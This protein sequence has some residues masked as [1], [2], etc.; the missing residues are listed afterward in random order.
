MSDSA[1]LASASICGEPSTPVIAA[2]GPAAAQYP[3]DVSRPATQ[4]DH[5][6]RMFDRY[7]RDQ[8]QCR[9]QAVSGEARVLSADP[10]S[11]T[12]PSQAPGERNGI[13][14]ASAAAHSVSRLKRT[15]SR[16]ISQCTSAFAWL[17]WI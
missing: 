9:T 16:I 1:F 8:I 12:C 14:T 5:G 3:R 2:V 15:G 13:A 10:S 17:A 7:A 11:C 4:V 6:P